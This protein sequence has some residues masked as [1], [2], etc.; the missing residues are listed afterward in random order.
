M[1][2]VKM[3]NKFPT[4]VVADMFSKVRGKSAIAKLSNQ[5]P[6]AFT[7]NSIF[8]FNMDG[9]V[10]IVAESGEKPANDSAIEPVK[11]QPVK[12]VFQSRFSDEFMYASEEYKLEVIKAFAD[13]FATKLATG[14][15]KMAMHG[16]NPATGSAS[17]LIT[18]HLDQVTNKVVYV[19]GKGDEA[20]EDAVA[21]LGDYDATGLAL[22]K[23][24]AAAMAKEVD[25]ASRKKFPELSWGG[26]PNAINGVPTDVNSTVSVANDDLAIVGDFNAFKWG[27]AK[28]I[29]VEVIEFGN[30]D[31]QGDL[32]ATNEIVLRGEAYIGFAVLDKDAF[33]RVT[34][35]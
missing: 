33:A 29:P 12:V 17:A 22:S 2:T 10:N 18:S 1:S 4:E 7:G 9:D 34:S 14:L 21:L 32:K 13:G 25:G 5:I 30:P 8:T 23:T 24:L 27:Y 15:D 16:I 3:G 20:I 19:A 35:K 28:E 6:V 26:Q 11:I 31:G